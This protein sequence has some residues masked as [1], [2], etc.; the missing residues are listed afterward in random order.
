MIDEHTVR[1]SPGD[2]CRGQKK[3]K[4]AADVLQ[5]IC[6]SHVWFYTPQKK[7][8]DNNAPCTASNKAFVLFQACDFSKPS[9]QAYAYGLDS[10]K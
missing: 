4:T 1:E 9:L 3:K 8:S 7:D 10:Q 5:K 2:S 6:G